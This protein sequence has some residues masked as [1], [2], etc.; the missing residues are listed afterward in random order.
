MTE[1][2]LLPV[3]SNGGKRVGENFFL[4]FS[5]ERID[6]GNPHYNTRNIPKV[7]GGVTE[8]CTECAAAL[9]Q[10]VTGMLKKEFGGQ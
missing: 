7:V 9:Y 1:E 4:A 10:N 3:L 2:A 6:P 5:P 8:E